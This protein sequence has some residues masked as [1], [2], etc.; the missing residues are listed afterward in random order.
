MKI[1]QHDNFNRESIAD[2]LVAENIKSEAYAK[3][4]CDALQAKYGG[5]NSD[6]FF[7]VKNDD[8]RLWRGMAELV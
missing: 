7:Q 3:V 5:E 2:F 1:V 8:Y 6:A 4:M